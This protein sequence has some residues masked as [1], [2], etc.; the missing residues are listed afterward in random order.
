MRRLAIAAASILLVL[1]AAGPAAA[2][3]TTEAGEE[4]TFLDTATQW[5]MGQRAAPNESVNPDAYA[6]L[7]AEAAALPVT[8]GTWTERTARDYFTDSPTY[9]PIGANCGANCD[10][11]SGSGERYV[12][13]RMTALAVARNGDVFA[14]AADGGI[15]KSTDRGAH[16]TPV[17]DQLGTMSIGALLIDNNS[18]GSG[19][20]VY[21]GT[22]ER[23][24]AATPTPVSASCD[25]PTAAPPG[26]SCRPRRSPPPVRRRPA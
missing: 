20:T 24:G 19:Y 16:W 4:S 22:G 23:T 13:G 11:N 3:S 12:S 15:W 2:G 8:G 9:A 26:P 1:A 18:R 7:R 10:Q 17:G 25:P 6:A 5:F 21:A 14:G